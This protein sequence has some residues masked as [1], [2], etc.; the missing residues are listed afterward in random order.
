MK[1]IFSEHAPRA[2]GPY[3][4][5]IRTGN[6]LYCS[7]QTPIDPIT[8]KI[9][10]TDI[11]SQTRRALDN[12]RVVLEAAGLSLSDVV[13]TN[14]FLSDI[15]LFAKMNSVYAEIFGTHR[16]ARSTIAVK[17]LPHNALVEIECIAEHKINL[18]TSI[19]PHLWK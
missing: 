17:G 8:M 12:L 11:E 18:T 5:A 4:Q 14:V 10:S 15:D 6:V 9:E 19:L 1:S 13:K 2:I 3:S 7:G 16:P